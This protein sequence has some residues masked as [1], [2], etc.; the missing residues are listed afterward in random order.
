[1][2][3]Y[4]G[5]HKCGTRWI[6][7]IL[8]HACRELGLGVVEVHNAALVKPDLAGFVQEH[9]VAFLAYTNADY[10]EARSLPDFRGF[11]VIRDPR[12]IVVSAYFSHL[13]S[14]PVPDDWPQLGDIR[15]TLQALDKDEGLLRQIELCDHEFRCLAEWPYGLPGVLELRMED[16]TVNP[17]GSMLEVFSFLGLLDDSPFDSRRLRH[18][19]AT[20]VRGLVGASNGELARLPRI[21]AERLLGIVHANDFSR[22]SGGRRPGEEDPRSHY[23]K[24]VAGDWRNHFTPRHIEAFKERY[25]ELLLK[26]G[27]ETTPDWRGGVAIERE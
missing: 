2:F 15:R 26:L 6:L 20:A 14:H 8:R 4:F 7:A 25:N 1:M 5:H 22:K 13:Y 17:Y 24:G 9:R 10:A 21:P 16:V 18:L 19:L 3:A 12:D 23:R 11:H 27:Y